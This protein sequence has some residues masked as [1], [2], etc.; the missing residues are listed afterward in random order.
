MFAFLYA[1]TLYCAVIDRKTFFTNWREF[2]RWEEVS[3][4]NMI[5]MLLRWVVAMIF[6]IGFMYVYDP[7]RL[8]FLPQHN[9]EIIWRIMIFYPI[10]SALPQEYVFCR[11]IFERY[12]IFFGEK[13]LMIFVSAL[14]FA[15]AHILFINWVAPLFGFLAGVIFAHTYWKTKSLALVT[16]EHA[17]YG[18]AIFVIGMGWYF[19]A[20]AIGS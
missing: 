7:E 16:I 14:I 2:W 12:K 1:A 20:G 13:Y 9:P 3:I 18:N 8:F 5:P 19:Y 6:V 10:F 4:K 11:F 15:I 17:L